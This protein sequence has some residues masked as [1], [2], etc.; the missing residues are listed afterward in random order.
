MAKATR[1][2]VLATLSVVLGACAGQPN[3]TE[4]TT[5]ITCP[6]GTKCAAVQQVCII[7]D[8]G[9]GIVQTSEQCDDGNILDGD[10]CAANCL[11]REVCG[12]G[13]LNSAA[14]ELCDDGNTTGGDGC[15]DDCRSVEICGNGIRDVSEACDD[16]NTVPGD[17]CSGNCKST[18]VCGNGIVDLNEKCDDGGAAGGCNDDCQGGTGCGDGA[19]DRDGSGNA[20]EECD[21]GNT[22]NQDDCTNACNLNVCG[23][24]IIQ[25]SGARIEGCDPGSAGETAACNLD[26]TLSTCGDNKINKAAGEECDLGPGANGDD[27]ACTA[28]C[29]KAICGDLLVNSLGPGPVEQCDDMNTDQKDGCSNACTTPTCGNGIVEMGEACDDFNT[30]DDDGCSGTSHV[31]PLK[32]CQFEACGDGIVNFGEDC[33]AGLNT[34]GTPLETPTCNIDCTT[35]ECGD[36]KINKEAGEECDDGNDIDTDSC[37]KTTCKLAFCGDGVTGPGEACDDGD[38]DN[39]DSCNTSCTMKTCGDGIVDPGEEC[40]DDNTDDTDGCLTTCVAARCGDGEIWSGVE[41]C[42]D[43]SGNAY[44]GACLPD[45]TENVCGD[46]FVQVSGTG[47][48]ACDSGTN[49]G[50]TTCPYGVAS[51]TICNSSCTADVDRTGTYCGDG[52]EQAANNEVCDDGNNDTETTCPYN[53]TSPNCTICEAGCLVES[54]LTNGPWCGDGTV[55]SSEGEAC[56]DRSPTQS[57]GRC[58]NGCNVFAGAAAATAVLLASA[59][60]PST[61]LD[62]DTFTLD[63][64]V[65]SVVFEFDDDATLNTA[66]ANAITIGSTATATQVRDAIAGEIDDARGLSLP[67]GGAGLR[68]DTTNLSTNG[69]VIRNLRDSSIGNTVID[70]SGLPGDFYIDAA[71]T[72]GAAGDCASGM[73]CTH[74]EDCLASDGSGFGNCSSNTCQ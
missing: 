54:M 59:H 36:R 43:G 14:G 61:D 52:T 65:N 66:G 18:E 51:C 67:I 69:L 27:R 35:R 33:D 26:C 2:L 22:D 41:D 1:L 28:V 10:G 3:A 32:H 34:D 58:D 53:P 72:G 23:D 5:G 6:E 9:D 19:I 62:G 13:V 29:H 8:C 11:S 70:R 39:N 64:G 46:A 17:G 38:Q 47:P 37:R 71:F 55:Q 40:D 12:D 50:A 73:P 24:T 25:T 63:D 31:D 21:D 45:C 15:A 30:T 60:G 49:N 68:M 20:L 7:N 16:G 74:D 4:C 48:E 56:D 42:D 57:C 44:T